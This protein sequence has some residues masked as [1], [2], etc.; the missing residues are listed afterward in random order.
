MNFSVFF[1]TFYLCFLVLI[2]VG[3]VF[4]TTANL[5]MTRGYKTGFFCILGCVLAD[6]IFII[7]GALCAKAV[8]ALIPNSVI[9]VLSLL[10][11]GFLLHIAYGFWK[12]DISK[13]K[14]EKINKKSFAL[15]LKMFC[16]TL[17]SPLSIIGYGAIFSSVVDVNTA[18]MSAILGGCC[19]ACFT[20]TLIVLFFGTLGKKINVK[21]LSILN[22]VSA[23]LISCFAMLLVFN[24][25][26]TLFGTLL[27]K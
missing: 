21:I 25:V 1:Q 20:H 3:P 26:K 2:S 17:S 22:R 10:A 14:T 18:M 27:G 19:A 24:F 15:S 23:I 5:S 9:M 16:L 12:T 13:I 4:I 7:A 11:G 8:I 6:F